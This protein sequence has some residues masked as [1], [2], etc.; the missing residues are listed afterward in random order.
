MQDTELSRYVVWRG[1]V[2]ERE[3]SENREMFLWREDKEEGEN[4]AHLRVQEKDSSQ[5]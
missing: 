1:E 3:A 4:V 2:E 5:K